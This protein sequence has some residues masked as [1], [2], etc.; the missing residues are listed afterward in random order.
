[1]DLL[2]PALVVVVVLSLSSWGYAHCTGRPA[3]GDLVSAS[4]SVPSYGPAAW[5]NSLG[6]V[7]V[8][9]LIAILLL[10]FTGWRP[11]Y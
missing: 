8:L 7:G 3:R 5:S 4:E 11:V 6:I 9:L 1:M 2:I 10:L